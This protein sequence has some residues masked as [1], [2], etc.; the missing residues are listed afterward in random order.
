M[1]DDMINNKI[2]MQ[3]K[4][5][6]HDEKKHEENKKEIKRDWGFKMGRWI[7]S[8]DQGG[9]GARYGVHPHT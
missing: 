3:N 9:E 1:H 5:K 6:M 2:R 8:G 7:R 4:I